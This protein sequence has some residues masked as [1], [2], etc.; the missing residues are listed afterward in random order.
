MICWPKKVEYIEMR[1]PLDGNKTNW[2]TL[3]VMG[4]RYILPKRKLCVEVVWVLI[5]KPKPGERGKYIIA[6]FYYNNQ[7]GKTFHECPF[8]YEINITIKEFPTKWYMLYRSYEL[9]WYIALNEAPR[10]EPPL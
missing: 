10:S 2:K 4:M 9:H 5:G 7:T 1:I 6:L 8:L 3:L